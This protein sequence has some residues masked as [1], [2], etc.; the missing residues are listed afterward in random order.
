M[1]EDADRP[2]LGIFPRLVVGALALLGLITLVGWVL[3]FVAGIT[4]AAIAVAVLVLLVLW[5]RSWWRD[6][7]RE[8]TA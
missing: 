8:P 2:T 5:I 7:R 6:R 1:P 4:K 3:S